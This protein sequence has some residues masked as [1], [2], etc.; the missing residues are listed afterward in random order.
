M[1]YQ[2]PIEVG[3]AWELIKQGPWVGGV[4]N[5]N[6]QWLYFLVSDQS[7]ENGE[8]GGR[9]RFDRDVFIPEGQ[10]LYVRATHGASRV[11]LIDEA[12]QAFPTVMAV[13]F[14]PELLTDAGGSHP[15][16][17]TDNDQTSFW[18]GLQ[19]RTFYKFNVPAGQSVFLQVVAAVNTVV[20]SIVV[21]VQEGKMELNTYANNP[22]TPGTPIQITSPFSTTSIPIFRNN[23][24]TGTPVI[25]NQD[26]IYPNGAINVA[27]ALNTDCVPVETTSSSAQ[28]SSIGRSQFE[29]RGV[30][31]ATRYWEIK[32]TGNSNARGVFYCF[33]EERP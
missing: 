32:N 5:P 4:F 29:Q 16:L 17:R 9:I 10:N 12:A 21:D 8:I 14:P 11:V 3:E 20:L 24:M 22:D 23:G 15:R 18:Q 30:S 25:P 6:G 31:P 33:W 7:P 2:A 19:Y 27:T 28:R 26:K 1:T 13:T